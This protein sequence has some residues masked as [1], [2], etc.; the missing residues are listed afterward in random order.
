MCQCDTIQWQCNQS[1]K[2]LSLNRG[3]CAR[4]QV[5]VVSDPQ[6]ISQIL[7]H[8]QFE[9]PV[10]W[11]LPAYKCP[12]RVPSQCDLTP[13]LFS[14]FVCRQ[15]HGLRH[16]FSLGLGLVFACSTMVSSLV[17]LIC[18]HSPF[19]PL[20][21]AHC[22]DFSRTQHKAPHL[23]RGTILHT[24]SYTDISFSKFASP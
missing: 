22:Q 5:P 13:K 9:K 20:G 11:A 17:P 16:L 18:A 21:H 4:A 6:L 15:E 7:E 8:P 19:F 23:R 24:S 14:T 12:M 10:R 3:F 2:M 1:L